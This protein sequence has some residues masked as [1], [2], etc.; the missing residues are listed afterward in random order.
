MKESYTSQRVLLP[1]GLRPATLVVEDGIITAIEEPGHQAEDFGSKVLM[2]GIIDTHVHINEPGRTHW[3]GFE[4]ATR[5]AAA[6]GLTTLVDMPLNCIPSTVDAAALQGKC[7]VAAPQLWVDVGFWGA[8][9]PDNLE[10][11]AGL[12]QA[13]V[14]GFKCFLSHPGTE[15]FAHLNEQQLE[16]AML[17]IA[18]LGSVLLLHA[19]EP[20]LLRDFTGNP[21]DYH[22]YLATRPVEAEVAS[23]QKVLRLAQKTGCRCH[24]VHV[25]CQEGASLFPVDGVTYE[26]CPHYLYF[27]AEEVPE[28][29][30]RLKCAP[31][32]RSAAQRDGLWQALQR[33][34]ISLIASDHSPSPADLKELD[35][36]DFSKAWGGISSLQLVLPA[37]WTPAAERGI[38][39]AQVSQWL[40]AAPAELAGL[41]A[42]KGSLRVGLDADFVVFDPDQ[43]FVV[44][45][46]FHRHPVTPYQGRTLK[47]VVETTFLRGQRVFDRGQ[48]A[49]APAG[50]I[51]SRS[52]ACSPSI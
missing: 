25:A 52:R 31:P 27:S 1:E 23:I 45:D 28:G 18:R 15:E 51:L 48:W 29:D 35:S 40:S 41:S 8:A 2:P 50:Q 34:S 47:G 3:E 42:R 6:G 30:T 36:G 33:G 46:L 20:A 19:E 9:V 49:K 16:R 5:S 14:L 4:S 11:L 13:G 21:R 7:S 12:Q 43:H 22:A 24:V 39:L 26:T 17:E 38:E 10:Q 32:I 37:V 44:G